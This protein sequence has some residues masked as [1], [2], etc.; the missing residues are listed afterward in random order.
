[1]RLFVVLGLVFAAGATAVDFAALSRHVERRFGADAVRSLRDWQELREAVRSLD[2]TERVRRV[3]EFFNSRIR[4]A[5]DAT[6]WG[7]SDFWATPV[8]TLARAAGDCEDFT[9]AKY[10]TLR[11]LGV[12][13]GRLR[14]TYVKARIGGESSSVTQAHMVLAYYPKADAEPLVLDNLLQEIRPA[15]KR[16]DLAPVFS[17]NSEGMWIDGKGTA[18]ASSTVRLSRWRDLLSRM[19]DEGFD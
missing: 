2:E 1:L 17:F 8:E 7:V 19:K 10:F 12:P 16:P 18:A 9:I 15:S 14:L 13:I 6:T 11:D 4:F 5:E 3:H